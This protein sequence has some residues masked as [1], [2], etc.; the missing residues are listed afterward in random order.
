MVVNTGGGSATVTVAVTVAVA[1]AVAV[2][3]TVAV[4]AGGVGTGWGVAAAHDTMTTASTERSQI[5]G[6]SGA[7]R[8]RSNG[9]RTNAHDV[10]RYEP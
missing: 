9:F 6:S 1:V 10:R 8:I 3:V 4:G 7:Y 2:A 5:M